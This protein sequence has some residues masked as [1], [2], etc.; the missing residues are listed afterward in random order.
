MKKFLAFLGVS[1]IAPNI[2][3]GITGITEYNNLKQNSPLVGH[4]AMLL[5]IK[6]PG[7]E[8]NNEIKVYKIT[9]DVLPNEQKYD[10]IFK[11]KSELW[12]EI[13][14]LWEIF[15]NNFNNKNNK[16]IKFT[17]AVV[18]KLLH[19]VMIDSSIA[20]VPFLSMLVNQIWSDWDVINDF[21]IE[22]LQENYRMVMNFTVK[23]EP[24]KIERY[25]NIKFTL[26]SIYSDH[27]S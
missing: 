26:C 7:I 10:I 27:K 6:Q 20:T 17:H 24:T 25:S 12:K 14:N 2:V 23:Y 19:S 8:F 16:K 21:W 11:I 4:S 13:K 22:C 5:Q 1:M 3:F 9:T 15:N 18:A